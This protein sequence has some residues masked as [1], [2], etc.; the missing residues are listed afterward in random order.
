MPT[1]FSIPGDAMEFVDE[2]ERALGVGGAFHVDANE[3]LGRHAGGFGDESANDVVG[4]LFVDVE[5]HVGEFEADVGVQ[6]VDGDLIEEV[7]VE[8]GAGAGFVGVGDIFA[9]VI[10]GDAGS[11]LIDGGGGAD[12]IGDLVAGY[13]AGGGALAEARAL[14]DSAEGSA[15]G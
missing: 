8:L 15:L 2:V 14:G 6:F 11:E 10:D 5:A 1:L 4:H 13:E 3:V 9:E 12:G 7:V